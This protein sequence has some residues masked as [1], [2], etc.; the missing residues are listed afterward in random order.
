MVRAMKGALEGAF[1]CAAPFEVEGQ[2]TEAVE[3]ETKKWLPIGCKSVVGG[4]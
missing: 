1:H 2:G 3:A 4:V